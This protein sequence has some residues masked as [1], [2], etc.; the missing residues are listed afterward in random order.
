MTFIEAVLISVWV[1]VVGVMGL[2][3]VYFTIM[4]KQRDS[5]DIANGLVG[6]CVLVG[7]IYVMI[8]YARFIRI[9]G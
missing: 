9:V 8:N 5:H 3:D 1:A 6:L 4:N 2:V 7:A